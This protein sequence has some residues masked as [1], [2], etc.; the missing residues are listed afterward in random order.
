MKRSKIKEKYLQKINNNLNNSESNNINNSNN[1]VNNYINNQNTPQDNKQP[2]IIKRVNREA[3]FIKSMLLVFLLL[4]GTS[5]P[6][7][8]LALFG[9]NY[10]NFSQEAKIIYTIICDII[11]LGVILYMYRRD[12]KKDF[13][14]FFNHNFL[15]NIAFALAFW[16]A[17]LIVMIASNFVISIIT[18]GTIAQ[19]EESVRELIEKFPLYMLLNITIYA[20]LTEEL[21]F[22]K[23]FRDFIQNKY[24]YILTS[25]L[26]FGF[27]HII[28]SLTD[29]TGILFLI[30]YSALGIAFA[31]AYEESDNIFTTITIHSLHN[32]LSFIIMM[33]GQYLSWKKF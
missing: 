6:M 9:I 11:V 19:N 5:I 13:K 1:S 15:Y 31:A 8:I 30:P 33:I 25:G 7:I 14:N 29:I 3:N 27:L 26:V 32:A 20:P 23:S 21:I 16:F 2:K 24:L 10:L 28:S 12:L 4:F 18:N 22:R 17:G